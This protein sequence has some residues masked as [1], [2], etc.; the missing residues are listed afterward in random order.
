MAGGDYDIVIRGG[1]IV[2]GTGSTPFVGDVAILNGK[3]AKVGVVEGKGAE[4]IDAAGKLV[5]PGWVDI[6]THYDGQVTW[7]ERVVPSSMQG[8]T[9][10]VMGNCGVGFAPVRPQDHE[11]LIKLMEGVEDIPGTA[12]HAGLRWDWETFPEYLDML[13]RMPRDI[14]IGT[15][16]P[17]SA[18]RVYVMGERGADREPATPEEIGRMGDLVRE[19]IDAGALGFSSSRTI[20]HRSID[21]KI[22]PSVGAAH[23]EL[24]GIASKLKGADSGV[25]QLAADFYGRDGEY[26]VLVDMVRASGRPLSFSFVEMEGMEDFWTDVSAKLADAEAQGLP[27]IAQ[28]QGRAVGMLLSLQGSVHPFVTKPSYKAI[29]HLPL[30]ERLA[31][32]RN[33]EFKAKLLAEKADE[34]HPFV[35]LVKRGWHR[36]FELGNPPNY[37]PA[38]VTS[39]SA[40]AVAQGRDVQELVYDVLTAGDGTGYL[41]F[42]SANYVGGSFERLL[43]MLR[44]PRTVPGLSDGGAHVGV[45][46]DASVSTYMLAHW[47]RDRRGEKLDLVDVVRRQTRETAA[48]VGLFDRGVVAPGYR[49][50][51]NVID[52]DRLRLLPPRMVFDLPMGERRLMQD[53]EGYVATLVAGK[54]IY[55]NGVATGELPG[56]LIRGGQPAPT[57]AA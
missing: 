14:D 8:T 42:P 20:F 10:A 35:E 37:E 5:T 11:R 44:H 9:T 3:I 48:A 29:M 16:V 2:D 52:F 34:G 49:A 33:P 26:Q 18:L 32:M 31:I 39:M 56:R 6:H 22:A 7:E 51:I 13:E 19:A 41:Y 38:P 50:D 4:E 53:A 57:A 21:G 17:H 25:L 1:E 12:L 15:Q 36:L 47:C 40:R 45:I 24:V 46:C 54:V 30:P 28:V 43:P 55:R 23:A 27:I